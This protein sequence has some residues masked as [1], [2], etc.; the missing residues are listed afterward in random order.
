MPEDVRWM[1]GKVIDGGRRRSAATSNRRSFCR[2]ILTNS[3]TILAVTMCLACER[4]TGFYNS[5]VLFG[6]GGTAPP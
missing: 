1:I 5:R 3:P 4:L 6:A 2:S